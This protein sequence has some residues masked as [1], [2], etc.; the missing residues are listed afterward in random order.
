[1]S[2][3]PSPTRASPTLPEAIAEVAMCYPDSTIYEIF[4]DAKHEELRACDGQWTFSGL[5]SIWRPYAV[6]WVQHP[7]IDAHKI[8]REMYYMH[9]DMYEDFP[10]RRSPSRPAWV[11]FISWMNPLIVTAWNPFER[12]DARLNLQSEWEFIEEIGDLLGCITPHPFDMFDTGW[13]GNEVS[14]GVMNGITNG[15]AYGF[16][17]GTAHGVANGTTPG[18]LNSVPNGLTNGY[19]SGTLNGSLFE[20]AHD[21]TQNAINGTAHGITNGVLSA[22]TNGIPNGVT[23]GAANGTF[24]SEAI[25]LPGNDPDLDPNGGIAVIPPHGTPPPFFVAVNIQSFIPYKMTARYLAAQPPA[26]P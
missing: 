1:M 21:M 10:P 22:N 11:C 2:E 7:S 9:R 6:W 12:E 5:L 18:V 14:N 24:F 17:N 13:T 26:T 8:M 19:T 23:N 3:T 4:L 25:A 15:T 16:A 20:P